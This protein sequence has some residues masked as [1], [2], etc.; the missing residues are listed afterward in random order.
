MRSGNARYPACPEL[1][2]PGSWYQAGLAAA[3]QAC[4]AGDWHAEAGGDRAGAAAGLGELVFGSGQ[5]DVQAFGFAGPADAVGSGDAVD[6]GVA[7][8]RCGAAGREPAR[9]RFNEIAAATAQAPGPIQ[10]RETSR[11]DRF[12]ET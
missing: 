4:R 10:R 2:K 8:L 5:A 1:D 7:D 6:Q 9:T 11:S 3:V 12:T